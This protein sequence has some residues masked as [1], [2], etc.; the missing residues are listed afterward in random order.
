MVSTAIV[1]DVVVE[2]EVLIGVRGRGRRRSVPTFQFSCTTCGVIEPV[3]FER[4]QALND[5]E[6]HRASAHSHPQPITR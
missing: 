6:V 1:F 3:R 2:G 5:K 4:A